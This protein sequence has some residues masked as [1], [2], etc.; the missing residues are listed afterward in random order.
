MSEIMNKKLDVDGNTQV[1]IVNINQYLTSDELC[2]THFS[3]LLSYLER[4]GE[5][6]RKD[7]M[8]NIKGLLGKG[9]VHE[10]SI[11]FEKQIP[12]DSFS[13]KDFD[14]IKTAT[15]NAILN[16]YDDFFPS[17]VGTSHEIENDG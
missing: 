16:D 15:Y 13:D 1:Y 4:V 11:N 2:N 5:S 14:D 7:G 12:I 17:L 9:N 10:L 6:T 8:R 3:F